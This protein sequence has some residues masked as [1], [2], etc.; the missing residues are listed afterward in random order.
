VLLSLR[1]TKPLGRTASSENPLL[2][3]QIEPPLRMR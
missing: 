3:G 2:A 1:R